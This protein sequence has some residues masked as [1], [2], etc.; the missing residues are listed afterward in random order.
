MRSNPVKARLR[1]GET[2]F[3]CF[4][5]TT[6]AA[7]VEFVALQGWDF[8]VFDG[9]HGPLDTPTLEHLLRATEARGATALAR[10]ATNAPHRI[11]QFLDA[12]AMGLHV[13]VINSTTEAEA[14]IQAIK[15]PPRGA[16]GLAGVRANAW[17]SRGTLAEYIVRANAETMAVLHI[18]TDR[19]V[20]DIEAIAAVPD[21]DVLFIGT[22]DLSSDLG[23]P[24]EFDHPR[25]LAAIHHVAEVTHTAGVT[26]GAIVR[27]PDD[28]PVWKAR[29]AR[30]FVVT[31]EAVLGPAS[32]GFLA[33]ARG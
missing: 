32:R 26:L 7:L 28:I 29:G 18:E 21:V 17:N 19:A 6:D 8:L 5:R 9:E 22:T 14:A 20:S 27:S 3:G 11:L 15:Y 31:L 24:G 10:V 2:V 25:L 4:T 30:Y 16:R 1:A 12:G 13:P 23:I 33:T